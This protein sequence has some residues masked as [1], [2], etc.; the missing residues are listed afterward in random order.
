MH[1][2][3]DA[4]ARVIPDGLVA[5]APCLGVHRVSHVSEP[6]AGHALAD[7]LPESFLRCD[8]QPSG[9]RGNLSDPRCKSGIRLPSVQDQRAVH[10]DDIAFLQYDFVAGN[11]VHHHVVHAGADGTGIPFIPFF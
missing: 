9:L 4:M 1:F 3:A 8:D 5:I 11:A 7:A 10:R 2:P 6:V